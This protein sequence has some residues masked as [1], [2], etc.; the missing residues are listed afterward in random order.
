MMPFSTPHDSRA[1]PRCA[2]R[3][4]TLVELLVVITLI[5][6]MATFVVPAFNQ[7]QSAEGLSR[8]GQI[9]GDQIILARQEAMTK[10]RKVEVRLV[11]MPEA[12][13]EKYYRGVQLWLLDEKGMPYK[14]VAKFSAFPERVAIDPDSA[15]SPL[16]ANLTGTTNFT[17]GT[18]MKYQGFIVRPS[19]SLEGAIS[20]NSNY[21]TVRKVTDFGKTMPSGNYYAVRVNPVTGRLSIHRP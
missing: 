9:L 8:A 12:S 19:G 10:N 15:S 2:T 16:L 17:G 7:I 13:G 3:A 1:L 6:I 18:S 4:F 20:T 5:A 21:L 14:P 11:E